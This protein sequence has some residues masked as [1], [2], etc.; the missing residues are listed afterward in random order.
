MRRSVEQ[1]P[2]ICLDLL[3]LEP[4]ATGGMEVHAYELARR[5]P[6]AMPE[7]RFSVLVGSELAAAMA[8]D[9]WHPNLSVIG[10]P[11]SASSRV[12]RTAAEFTLA[13]AAVRQR[14]FALVHGL[15]NLVPLGPGPIRVVT[16]HDV[17]PL[18][19]PETTSR[20]LQLGLRGLLPLVA[21]GSDL[22]VTVSEASRR[23]I[24]EHLG[25][26]VARVVPI[27]SGPGRSEKGLRVTPESELRGRL[28][29]PVGPVVLAVAARRPHKNLTR[30]IS[31][32]GE[33][34]GAVLVVPGYSTA[35]DAALRA[36]AE[37]AGLAGRVV[38]TGWLDD[39]DLEGLYRLASCLCLP[40]LAEGFGLPVVE[41]MRRGVPVVA[42]D[43]PV[44]REV[45]GDAVEYVDPLLSSS[46]AAGLRRV[47]GDG[48]HRD[49]LV[50]LGLRRAN[51]FSW[52]SVASRHA[53]VYRE[54]LSGQGARVA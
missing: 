15:G 41:A 40:T 13:Y 45:G 24:T 6:E 1:P 43:I 38:F 23:A 49:A 9:P 54:L 44:L 20:F 12:R 32:L 7:A 2:E 35:Y 47:L 26:P 22:V 52:G 11:V 17:I 36:E 25:V 37:R 48:A 4:S 42:S 29:L 16:I 30:L 8:D 27:P 31:A 18:T 46:I 28:G 50:A 3:F 10:L 34:D 39:A 33:V 5:L 21:R 51:V 19:H 14:R 53:D